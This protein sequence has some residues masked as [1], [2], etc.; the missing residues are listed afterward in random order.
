MMEQQK[1]QIRTQVQV[2]TDV[3]WEK[4][5]DKP[6]TKMDGKTELCFE[7][8]VGRFVDVSMLI[9]NRFSQTLENQARR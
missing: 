7:N 6:S 3:C 4:C 8:C 9:L 2:L 5:M 1:A